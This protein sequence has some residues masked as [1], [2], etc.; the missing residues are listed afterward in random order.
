MEEFLEGYALTSSAFFD[1]EALAEL[2]GR[3][4]EKF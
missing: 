4:R 2:R 3:Q 1:K